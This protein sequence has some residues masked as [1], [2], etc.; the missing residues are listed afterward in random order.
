[1]N[2][3]KHPTAAGVVTLASFV[4]S[5]THIFTVVAES[6]TEWV[7][8]VYPIGIDGLLYVGIRAMQ[9]GRKAIGALALIV[10][11]FYS[12]LFNADAENAIKMDALLIA[13]SMPTCVIVSII[14]ETTAKK[15]G[16]IAPA[17]EVERV[18]EKVVPPPLLPIVPFASRPVH[19][20]S[21][22]RTTP[23]APRIDRT[24]ARPAIEGR[25]TRV[26][27]WDVEKAVRLLAD[28]RTDEDVLAAVD[29]LGAKPW[30]RTKRAVRLL[31]EIPFPTDE[32]VS[33]KVGQSAAHVARVR[34]A[35]EESGML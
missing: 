2:I 8:W 34:A 29:G 18:V 30:Q 16:E 25:T 23:K 11:A 28:G 24:D 14:I 35:M 17:R 21:T 12:L 7:A 10:G 4:A 19:V 33:G 9:T 26:A 20:A 31:A 1:M 15:S 6:N 13:A 27:S 3:L 32:E 5:A 22:I